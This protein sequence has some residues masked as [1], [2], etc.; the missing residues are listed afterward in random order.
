MS[1][2]YNVDYGSL[3]AELL[4]PNKRQPRMLAFVRALL[5]ALQYVLNLFLFSYRTGSPMAAWSNVTTYSAGQRVQYN[6]SIYESLSN[7]NT[8]T[9]TN[10]AWWRLVQTNFL[11]VEERMAYSGQK[12]V[13][14]YAL[15]RYFSTA[16]VQ[17]GAGTS[18]IYLTTNTPPVYPFIVGA[19][20]ASTSTTYPTYS[21]EMV[22]NSYSFTGNYRF[23]IHMPTAVYTALSSVSAARDKIV[24][25]FA[26]NYV[27]AGIAYNIVTY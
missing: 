19:V 15:N 22:L 6:R 20:N 24:R 9:P 12:V 27:P 21:T 5:S 14:E 18:D 23:T 25:S 2:I 7:S 26:D 3:G 11:G 10:A 4:P 13:I 16:F 8:A 1:S 17:P